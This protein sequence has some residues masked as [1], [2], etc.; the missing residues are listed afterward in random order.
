[1]KRD[2]AFELAIQWRDNPQL[3]VGDLR[4]TCDWLIK[5]SVLPDSTT[6]GA[7][8]VRILPSAMVP[9]AIERLMPLHQALA[10]YTLLLKLTKL[11]ADLLVPLLESLTNETADSAASA[12]VAPGVLL[13]GLAAF[14]ESIEL[15]QQWVSRQQQRTSAE[16]NRSEILK[17]TIELV[18]DELLVNTDRDGSLKLRG[19]TNIPMFLAFFRNPRHHLS[20]DAFLDIDR[21]VRATNL[22]RHRVRLSSKLHDVYIEIIEEKGG[23]RMRNFR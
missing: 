10:K 9:E 13:P 8:E 16:G 12:R 1:M 22:D 4:A 3:L 17:T 14:I 23:Y 2:D 6:S 5:Y 21:T 18:G 15:T 7:D 20:I 19:S 11:D